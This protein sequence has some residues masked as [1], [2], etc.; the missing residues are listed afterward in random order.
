[1]GG[2]ALSVISRVLTVLRLAFKVG[3][4]CMLGRFWTAYMGLSLVSFILVLHSDPAFCILM[5]A[6]VLRLA[7]KVWYVCGMHTCKK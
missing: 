5:L 2:M 6:T 1:M 4:L 3:V 7:V